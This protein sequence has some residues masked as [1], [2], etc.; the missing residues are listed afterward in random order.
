MIE[1]RRRLAAAIVIA[2]LAIAALG[3]AAPAPAAAFSGFGQMTAS[4]QYGQ[5]MTF[6][7]ALSGGTPDRLELL[8]QF[9]PNPDS[10]YVAPV[11]ASV[12]CSPSLSVAGAVGVP[13]GPT[14]SMAIER[15]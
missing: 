1:G 9:G 5:Q 12:P 6:T 10:T 3:L 8:L 13:L 14:L 4:E 7:V 11:T 2:S 15:L